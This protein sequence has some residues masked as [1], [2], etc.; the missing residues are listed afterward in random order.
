MKAGNGP[1]ESR[2]R[3]AAVTP[4]AAPEASAGRAWELVEAGRYRPI[5][6]RGSFPGRELG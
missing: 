4:A 5:R 6:I 2:P 3:G 1:E